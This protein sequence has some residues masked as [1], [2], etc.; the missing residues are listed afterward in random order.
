MPEFSSG[1][2]EEWLSGKENVSENIE[3]SIDMIRH[4][5]LVPSNVKVQGFMIDKKVEKKQLLKFLLTK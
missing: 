1:S 3:K 2:L 4:H 5:P